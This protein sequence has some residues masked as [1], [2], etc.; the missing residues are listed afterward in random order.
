[1]FELLN[2]SGVQGKEVCLLHCQLCVKFSIA[3]NETFL[4][5]GAAIAGCLKT[6]I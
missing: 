3:N 5:P 1:M 4:L 6:Y 2:V